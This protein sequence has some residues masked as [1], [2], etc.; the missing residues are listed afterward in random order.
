MQTDLCIADLRC[1]FERYELVRTT[2]KAL[3]HEDIALDEWSCDV[4]LYGK[5]YLHRSFAEPYARFE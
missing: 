4:K 3:W 1:C 5:P 2:S